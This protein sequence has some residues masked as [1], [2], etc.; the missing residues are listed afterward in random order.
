MNA[1][2]KIEDFYKEYISIILNLFYKYLFNNPDI[3]IKDPENPE[4]NFGEC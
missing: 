2:S 1:D 4:I 3:T